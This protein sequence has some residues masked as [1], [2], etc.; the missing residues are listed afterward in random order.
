MLPLWQAGG[1][2]FTVAV[3]AILVL[4]P[5]ALGVGLVDRPGGRKLHIG[6]V[7]LV[8]GAAILIALLIGRLVFRVPWPA[9]M[10]AYL[11]ACIAIVLMGILDDRFELK[12]R[13]RILLGVACALLIVLY[14]GL[15]ITHLGALFDGGDVRLDDLAAAFSVVGIVGVMNG[16]NLLDGA[17]GLAG[18]VCLIALLA[19]AMA[20]G[21]T[22]AGGTQLTLVLFAGATCGFLVFNFR[23]RHS[24]PALAFLGDAGSLL[25]GFTLAVAAIHLTQRAGPHLSPIGAVWVCGVLVL[26]TVSLMARRMA[27]GKNPFSADRYHLHHLL[28]AAGMGERH[29]VASIWAVQIVL[30]GV[31]LAT[32]LLSV[33][34]WIMF[35]AFIAAFLIYNV[36][37]ELGWA[38]IHRRAAAEAKAVAEQEIDRRM[39]A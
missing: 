16:A 21:V 37:V 6:A 34:Q 15:R 1:L 7:P 22:G 39:A 29:A 30:S 24:R 26:D 25:L 27:R 9:W 2:G 38:A 31:G 13:L 3:A 4:R 14:G 23:L 17:N 18:G 10:G 20:A 12:R 11:I 35:A 5:I 33:P 19:F 8:G 28:M 32:W 36:G